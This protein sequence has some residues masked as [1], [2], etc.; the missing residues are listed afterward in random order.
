LLIHQNENLLPVK[1]NGTIFDKEKKRL[2]Y[3]MC[4]KKSVKHMSKTLILIAV[5]FLSI[6]SVY[7]ETAEDYYNRGKDDYRQGNLSQAI[8]DFTKAIEIN[9]N[10]ATA[11]NNRGNCY[12]HQGNLPQAIIEFTKAI[13][14][15]PKFAEAY[16]D[17]GLA[18]Y[19]MTE[20]DKSWAD[21]HKA[22]ELGY[23]LSQLLDLLKQASGRNK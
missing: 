23:D 8:S 14:I 18:Y 2:E 5:I 1:R 15:D 7:A 22:E 17:R 13:E 9:S 6:P 16:Y 3:K 12:L 19:L 4:F 11:Y 20:Y 21:V 10:Y